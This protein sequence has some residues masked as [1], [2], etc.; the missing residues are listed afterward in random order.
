[1]YWVNNYHGVPNFSQPPAMAARSLDIPGV[2]LVKCPRDSPIDY[3]DQSEKA[4]NEFTFCALAHGAE[5]KA[6][7]LLP[8][9]AKAGNGFTGSNSND[10]R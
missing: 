5:K 1:M 10:H 7:F 6:G 2:E 3:P 9:I 8:L 4:E